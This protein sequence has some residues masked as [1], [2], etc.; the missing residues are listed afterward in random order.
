MTSGAGIQGL[1]GYNQTLKRIYA[2]AGGKRMQ[3]GACRGSLQLRECEIDIENRPG[4]GGISSRAQKD[5]ADRASEHTGQGILLGIE[6]YRPGGD[7][8]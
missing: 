6:S 7:G 5:K 1:S 4:Q 2:G 3:E 8:Q